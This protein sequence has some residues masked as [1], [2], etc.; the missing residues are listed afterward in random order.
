MGKEVAGSSPAV[1]IS[2]VG[3][4]WV[5]AHTLW[6]NVPWTSTRQTPLRRA[7]RHRQ[8]VKHHR[9]SEVGVPQIGLVLLALTVLFGLAQ[10]QQSP[11][12]VA[13][14]PSQNTVTIAEC[15]QWRTKLAKGQK[16]SD[17]ERGRFHLCVTADG[18]DVFAPGFNL[19]SGTLP[20]SSFS[21]ARPK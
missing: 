5:A 14:S 10:A 6:A 13:E 4:Q 1:A 15:A 17:P 21:P 7:R 18:P 2:D 19:P 9:W 20:A 3:A 8:Y 11:S 12:L 16:L